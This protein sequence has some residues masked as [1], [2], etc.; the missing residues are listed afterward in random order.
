LDF[1]KGKADQDE[2]D[3]DCA[4]REIR[5][6]INIDVRSHIKED[7]YIRLETKDHKFTKLYIVYGIDDRT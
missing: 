6:E 4:I 3:L 2:S 7:R 1:P 5:E